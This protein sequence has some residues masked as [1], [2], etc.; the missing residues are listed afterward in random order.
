LRHIR[1]TSSLAKYGLRGEVIQSANSSR[2][3]VDSS[4]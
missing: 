2:R 3:S 1:L 4:G